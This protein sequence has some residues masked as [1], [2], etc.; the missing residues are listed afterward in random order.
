MATQAVKKGLG[1]RRLRASIAKRL[2]ECDIESLRKT[3]AQLSS[4]MAAAL[5]CGSATG[6][7]SGLHVL[8]FDDQPNIEDSTIIIEGVSG[9]RG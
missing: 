3:T 4:S 5:T 1:N 8:S 6:Y 2:V 7:K 9:K